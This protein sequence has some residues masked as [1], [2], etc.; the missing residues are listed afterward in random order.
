[1]KAIIH[2]KFGSPDYLKSGKIKSFIHKLYPL[3]STAEAIRDLINGWV[4][5]KAVISLEDEGRE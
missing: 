5:G 2:T 3:E 1:M 4:T